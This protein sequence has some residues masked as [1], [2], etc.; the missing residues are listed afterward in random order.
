MTFSSQ[1]HPLEP[2]IDNSNYAEYCI[3]PL[4]AGEQMGRGLVARDFE[5]HPLGGLAAKFDMPL[6]P[7]SQWAERIEYLEQTKSRL[8]DLAR[9]LQIPVKSQGNTNYCWI[10]APVWCVELNRAAQGQSHVE[11]SPASVGCKIKNFRNQ[12]GWGTEGLEYIIEHGVVPAEMWPANAITRRHDT[13]AAWI[14]A[15]KYKVSEWWDLEPGNFD[16]LM[17]CVLNLVPVAVGYN[18]WGHEVTALDGVILS[19]GKVGIRIGNSWGPSWGDNGFGI[20]T[21]SKAT[22]DDAVAPR[23]AVA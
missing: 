15:E 17:T 18:W 23:V 1:I 14:E 19:R 8:S 5:K 13:E 10:N 3:D 7:E 20:L 22:P 16:Q 2:V 4:V 11:L 12:G 9:G 6:I 21:R